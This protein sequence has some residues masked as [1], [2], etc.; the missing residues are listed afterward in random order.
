M[1]FYPFFLNNL[2]EFTMFSHWPFII[3]IGYWI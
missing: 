2:V 3:G 1:S